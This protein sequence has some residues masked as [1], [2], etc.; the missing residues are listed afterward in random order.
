MQSIRVVI[1]SP[2]IRSDATLSDSAFIS[3][4]LEKWRRTG[5]TAVP[6]DMSHLLEARFERLSLYVTQGFWLVV[7]LAQLFGGLLWDN[8]LF[9]E[10]KQMYDDIFIKR[11]IFNKCLALRIADGLDP[12]EFWA[13]L[14]GSLVTA[15]QWTIFL[16]W[17]ML[18]KKYR[19][20]GGRLVP[21]ILPFLIQKFQIQGRGSGLKPQNPLWVLQ[22]CCRQFKYITSPQ[23]IGENG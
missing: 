8:R 3:R 16:G 21:E 22:C 18:W 15:V 5:L 6:F 1:S 20:G 13:I 17:V 23:N 10:K 11:K 7:S 4:I 9:F 2:S 19:W 12:L 14:S